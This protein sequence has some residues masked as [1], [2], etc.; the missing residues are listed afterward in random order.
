[1]AHGHH[2]HDIHGPPHPK[3]P[4]PPFK[5]PKPIFTDKFRANIEFGVWQNDIHASQKLIAIKTIPGT[6][7]KLLKT[8]LE[9]SVQKEVKLWRIFLVIKLWND[10]YYKRVLLLWLYSQC[11]VLH[12]LLILVRGPN[13][14]SF[15]K[16]SILH[17]NV[18]KLITIGSIGQFLHHNCH[19][20]L[21]I[22][23][24]IVSKFYNP[25]HSVAK[26]LHT[27]WTIIILYCTSFLITLV[28]EQL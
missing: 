16:I 8:S 25:I 1:M 19:Q 7:K 15:Q 13:W 14:E 22:Q 4:K 11:N 6:S 26:F 2:H 5:Y 10:H 21:S 17:I 3:K 12:Y 28:M 23:T 27:H 9:K 24:K 20:L 18:L